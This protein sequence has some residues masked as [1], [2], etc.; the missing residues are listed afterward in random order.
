[1]NA[2]INSTRGYLFTTVER[3]TVTCAEAKVSRQLLISAYAEPRACPLILTDY[4]RVTLPALSSQRKIVLA[5]ALRAPDRAG[6]R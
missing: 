4:E 3:G 6:L 2:P 1:M 5:V